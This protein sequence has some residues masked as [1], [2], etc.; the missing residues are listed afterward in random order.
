[1]GALHLLA[2]KPFDEMIPKW[3]PGR[4]RTSTYLSGLAEIIGAVLIVP[5]ASRR[6]GGYWCAATMASV[7]PAN[8]QAALDG[9]MK[10]APPPFDTAAAAWIRL[11]FQVPMVRQALRVAR[12]TRPVVTAQS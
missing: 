7:Y 9:G 2:P 6:V 1:M 4:P 8:V 3:M 12:S 10:G 5:K 11:P